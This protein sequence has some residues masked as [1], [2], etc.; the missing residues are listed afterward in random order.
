MLGRRGAFALLTLAFLGLTALPAHAT[1]MV[2]IPLEDLIA[3]ADAIVHATV[4]RTG[5][6]LETFDGHLEP[7]TIAM[8]HVS[9]WL[10]G[11]G[12]SELSIDEIGGTVN[13]NGSWIDGTPRYQDGE[14]VIVFLR[15]LPNGAY[16]TVG[17]EQGRFDVVSSVS[18][19]THTI[20]RLVQR[21]TSTLAFASW[22]SGTMEVH[23]GT[24]SPTLAYDT[25]VGFITSVIEQLAVSGG[26]TTTGGAR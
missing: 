5:T 23:E 15:R 12:G 16:R 20:E 9:D 22:V 6:Q 26:T 3:D 13:G 14:E 7:H 18:M 19:T 17:M 24:R 10:K 11:T 2:E 1:V 25:F 21:D 4:A 8:L